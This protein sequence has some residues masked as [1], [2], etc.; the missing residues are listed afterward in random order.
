MLLDTS[1]LYCYLDAGDARHGDAEYSILRG[2]FSSDFAPH[3]TAPG[4]EITLTI[5]F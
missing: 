4:G 2:G 1:G 5:S 3:Y